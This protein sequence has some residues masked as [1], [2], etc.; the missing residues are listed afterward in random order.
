MKPGDDVAVAVEAGAAR[1]AADRG[2]DPPAGK[3]QIF[4]DLRPRLA[5][6]DNQDRA[7]LQG[8]RIAIYSEWS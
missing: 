6:A 1:S 3:L 4:G 2:R 5:G 7:L 8:L